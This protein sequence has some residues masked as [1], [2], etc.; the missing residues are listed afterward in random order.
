[1]NLIPRRPFV[2]GT[3]LFLVLCLVAV[4]ATSSTAQRFFGEGNMPPRYPPSS[5]PDR[6]FAFCKLMYRSIR[7]EALGMGWS[8]DYPY[9]GINLM[10]RFSDLTTAEVS[11]DRRGEPNHWVV[12]LSDRELF[13]CPFIMAADVG[14]IGLTVN[15]ATQLRN[16]LLKG[17]FLWVDDFWGTAAWRHWRSEISRVLPPREYPIHDLPLD[18]PIFRTHSFVDKVPQITAIQFWWR[19]G[20]TTSERGRDSEEAHLRAISDEHGRILVLMSHNT[21]VADAW[22]REGE[23]PRYFRQFSPDGYGLGINVLL[24][25]M[26]H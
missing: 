12:G 21:D 10:F 18:H 1:M 20:G 14:T 26:S 3:F 5:M 23:D 24:Y 8:T 19:S 17:G 9:A 4:L 16:Y 2:N 15:E 22:E 6:D 13:N 25:A 11:T 7:Y